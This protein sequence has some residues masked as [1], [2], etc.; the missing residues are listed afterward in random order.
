MLSN[1][2]KLSA[3]GLLVAGLSPLMIAGMAYGDSSNN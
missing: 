2:S 3:V 1:K